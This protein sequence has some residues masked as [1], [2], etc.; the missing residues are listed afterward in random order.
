MRCGGRVRNRDSEGVVRHGLRMG[1]QSAAH[2]NGIV[3]RYWSSRMAVVLAMARWQE[4]K[5]RCHTGGSHCNETKQSN[6]SASTCQRILRPLYRIEPRFQGRRTWPWLRDRLSTLAMVHAEQTT[7]EQTTS[8]GKCAKPQFDE[9]GYLR[10]GR[11]PVRPSLRSPSV[12]A[13]EE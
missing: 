10:R 9:N 4:K 1:R 11:S 6:T 12:G 2:N 5:E 7:S 13:W 3:G 8:C